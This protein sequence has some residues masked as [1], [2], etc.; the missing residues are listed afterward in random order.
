MGDNLLTFVPEDFNSIS[1][2]ND[3]TNDII[4]IIKP[5]RE[6]QNEYKEI[7][8]QIKDMELFLNI[9][10]NS[11]ISVLL[12][13]YKKLQNFSIKMRK[14]LSRFITNIE[15]YNNITY[16][17]YYNNE[18]YIT[19]EIKVEWLNKR[20]ES[21]EL[22]LNLEKAT[23]EIKNTLLDDIDINIQGLLKDHYLKYFNAISGMYNGVIGRGG[24]I[25]QGHIAEAFESHLALHHSKYYRFINQVGNK[26]FTI[27]K[28]ILFQRLEEEFAINYWADK[29]PPDAA[30]AHI[31]GALGRQRG[32]VA[33]DVGPMQ[34]KRG[35]NRGYGKMARLVTLKNLQTGI[36]YY[37]DII[38]PQI[39][40]ETVAR[41][42]AIYLSEQINSNEQKIQ[43]YIANKQQLGKNIK[44][45]KNNY[46]IHI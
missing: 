20:S 43:A 8:K 14:L 2:I 4:K 3:L 15:L 37:S 34:V 42:I 13:I 31:R 1:T 38:N 39:P 44:I 9:N 29:E 36:S 10:K 23:K 41:N 25:N 12:Q 18:R 40:I 33:G 28:I 46:I 35:A 5:I 30:W 19:E 22:L 26:N 17:F 27:D 24:K 6:N 7:I 16:A 45:D 21:G 11:D 32:T